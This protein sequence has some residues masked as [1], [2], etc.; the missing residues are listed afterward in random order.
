MGNK[1][2]GHYEV[3]DESNID[4]FYYKHF[5][6]THRRFYWRWWMVIKWFFQDLPDKLPKRNKE[7]MQFLH[8]DIQ[9]LKYYTKQFTFTRRSLRY[10]GK[11]GQLWERKFKIW[12]GY[13]DIELM[14]LPNSPPKLVKGPKGPRT[15][16][17]AVHHGSHYT[18][19]GLKRSKTWRLRL[20]FI[21]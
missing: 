11:D 10:V 4:E 3:I 16:K 2:N 9:Q 13:S 20:G 8:L 14:E 17:L 7:T 12:I 21:F 19:F 5:G 1:T 15:Y 18:W 6:E